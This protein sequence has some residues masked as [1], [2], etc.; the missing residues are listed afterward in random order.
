MIEE[1]D[2]GIDLYRI[3]YE[4]SNEKFGNKLRENEI[5]NLSQGIFSVMVYVNFYLGEKYL[6]M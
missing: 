3:I 6:A 2:K 4:I 5:A 1:I